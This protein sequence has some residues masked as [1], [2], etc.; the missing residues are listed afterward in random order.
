M[1]CSQC[2]NPATY[3]EQHR[4]WWCATCQSYLA[5]PPPPTPE[6]L[7]KA[8]SARKLVNLSHILGWGGIGMLFVGPIVGGALA[9]AGLAVGLAGLGL[10][11]AVA[12]AIVGQ[13]GRAQQGRVI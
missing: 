3:V 13:I 9:G 6:Q 11:S 1:N 5:A 12:G 4:Q 7:A 2:H 8:E 10:A